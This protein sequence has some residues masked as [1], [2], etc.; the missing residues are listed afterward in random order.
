MTIANT[1]TTTTAAK[2]ARSRKKVEAIASTPSATAFHASVPQEQLKRA[3]AKAQHAVAS[4]STMPV[5]GNV[6]LVAAGSQL[7]ISATN[8]E[9]GIVVS[10][11]AQVTRDGAI[12]L[13]AKLLA[14]VVGSLPNETIAMDM[15][16]RDMSVKLTCGAFAATIKGIAAEEF[17]TLPTLDH[18]APIATL[19][20]E[21]LCSAISQVAFA[22][23]SDETRP[24]LTSVRIRLADTSASFAAADSFRIAFRAIALERPVARRQEV[25]APARA[26]IAL[27]KVLGDVDGQVAM[28]I[29]TGDQVVFRS[30]EVTLLARCINGT[31]PAVDRYLNPTASPTVVEIET[32]ELAR[33]VKLASFFA[34]ASANVVRVQLARVDDDK[35]RLTISANAAEVG[36]NTSAHDATI[37]GAGGVVALNATYLADAIDAIATPRIA[38][39][40]SSA[41][42][43]I[44]VTGVGDETYIH[45]AMPMTVR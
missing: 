13:P 37:R 4:K 41:Q 12:T 3:L 16:A 10:L 7:T 5:L 45:V 26:M 33:A 38:I 25:M 42:Q 21:A 14:D 36:D 17:P 39:H 40:Y 43:P 18:C 27:G 9:I 30:E 6:L 44:I 1:A 31:Y 15:D 28:L 20:P 19:A 24:V 8:L 34:S 23:C 29:D 35:G 32:K 11:A 22:A 2:P